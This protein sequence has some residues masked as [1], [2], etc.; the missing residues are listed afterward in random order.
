MSYVRMH[1]FTSYVYHYLDGT[2]NVLP[3]SPS[4]RDHF[5]HSNV[6][7]DP[8]NTADNGMPIVSVDRHGRSHSNEEGVGQR[9]RLTYVQK[10]N[11]LL[12]T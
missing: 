3:P 9:G 5:S 8:S 1:V 7:P 4:V 6:N 11:M 2:T 12:V 10:T